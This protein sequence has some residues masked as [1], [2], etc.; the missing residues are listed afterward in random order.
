MSLDLVTEAHKLF[1]SINSF[2]NVS[3]CLSLIGLLKYLIEPN[4]YYKSLLMLEDAKN[5]ASSSFGELAGGVNR[6]AFSQIAFK[7]GN[8]TES[9]LY[10]TRATS[11]LSSYP[12]LQ[13]KV[14][15]T[16]AFINAEI[17]NFE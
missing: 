9:L 7:E 14:Y 8:Y 1:L 12:Y 13:I 4:S 5:L 15:E 6:F 3:I 16:Q 17:N 10:L 2:K 11:M